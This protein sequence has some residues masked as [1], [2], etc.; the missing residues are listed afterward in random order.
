MPSVVNTLWIG[1]PLGKIER[2]CLRSALRQG[3][4]VRLFCYEPVGGVPEGVDVADA[5]GILPSS[6]IMRYKDGSVALF[7]NLF[8]YALQ[9]ES[10]GLWADTDHYFLK[11]HEFPEPYV[12]GRQQNGR[13]AN[14]VLRIPPDSPLL[15]SLLETFDGAVI[16]PWANEIEKKKA[17]F[18]LKRDGSFRPEKMEWGFT[19]PRA[20]SHLAQELGLDRWA[21]PTTTFYP[22]NFTEADW[23]LDPAR[24]LED[25][26][27]PDSVGIHLWNQKI[28]AFKNAPAPRG[29]FLARLQA[30]GE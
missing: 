21:K 6:R 5:A 12:F 4:A 30:E 22:V 1:G 23:L 29:S 11:P 24:S 10:R 25:M 3:H 18:L 27:A 28:K 14:G 20:L 19:G 16:P 13:L 2:A 17:R 26:I 9:R 8:R 15:A 7:A